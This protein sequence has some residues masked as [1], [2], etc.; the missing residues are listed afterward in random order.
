MKQSP[1]FSNIQT[2]E[3]YY[4]EAERATFKGICFKTFFLLAITT[5]V[6]GFIAFALP[7]I[8]MTGNANTFYIILMVS[9]FV[10]FISVL[11]GRM[12]ERAAKY[13]SFIYSVC[14]G[15]FL[16]SLACVLKYAFPDTNIS[17][18]AVFSTLII[19]LIMLTLFATGILRVTNTLR[20]FAFAFSLGAIAL[21]MFSI[22]G[23]FFMNIGAYMGLM[24]FIEAFLLIYGVITLSFNFQEAQYVV[25]SGASKGAE[26]CVAL[27]LMVSLIYIYLEIVRLLMLI[28]ASRRD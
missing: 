25:Q 6:A 11:V 8:I 21:I 20:K 13:A 24:I 7:E 15:L 17:I 18:I 4:D 12:S 26:W 28:I 3:M 2:G 14:E 22:I 16:G 27:G 9:V 5:L 23:S 10:G 1:L 19:F